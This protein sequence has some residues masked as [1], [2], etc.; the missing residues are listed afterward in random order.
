[1]TWSL[2]F[3]QPAWTEVSLCCPFLAVGIRRTGSR[4]RRADRMGLFWC[5][6]LEIGFVGVLLLAADAGCAEINV[7][8]GATANKITPR[9]TVVPT[10]WVPHFLKSCG[11]S[12]REHCGRTCRCLRG[13]DRFVP[14]D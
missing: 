13:N 3:Q 10:R 12:S 1:M 9:H 5:L 6:Y 7:A 4:T 2:T 8:I 14:K 11:C